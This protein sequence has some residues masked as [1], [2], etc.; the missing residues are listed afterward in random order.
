MSLPARAAFWL[1]LLCAV[2]LAQG[3]SRFRV[4]VNDDTGRPLR[5]ARVALAAGDRIVPCTTDTSGSCILQVAPGDYTLKAELSGFYLASEHVTVPGAP[6]AVTLYRLQ[7]IK[8]EVEV[9]ATPEPIE[10]QQTTERHALGFEQVLELPYTTS[11]QL[12]NA[13]LLLP[14][15]L[16]DNRGQFHVAG[17]QQYQTLQLMDGFD[18]SHPA[19]GMLEFRIN[20]DAVREIAT[21]TTRY[22]VEDGW[23]S[24]GVLALTT[25]M[26]DDRFR[27]IATNFIPSVQMVKGV[28]FDK[29]VP[30]LVVSG[31][32]VR[33]RAWFY[34]SLDGEY[35]E[36][37][38]KELPDGADTSI[39]W[40]VGDLTKVQ[41]NL[42]K[43]NILT[44]SLLLNRGQDRHPGISIFTPVESTP[45][46]D[47]WGYLA[48]VKDQHYFGRG[49]LLE[50]GVAVN[51]YTT[52][53]TPAG[54]APY[55]QHPGSVSGN[56]YL[57]SEAAARRVEGFAD[58]YAPPLEALGRHEFK[59][60][61][62]ANDL[63]YSLDAVR[64]PIFFVR[65]DGTLEHKAEFLGPEFQDV[66]TLE[67][68]AYVEDHW[69]VTPRFV[70]DPGVRVDW[71]RV[72]HQAVPQPRIAAS[73]VLP[74]E[75]TTKISAGAGAYSDQTN[76]DLLART[77][78][79]QDT[80]YA[81]DGV[82]PVGPPS[83]TVF[84]VD[85]S[86]LRVA[87]FLNWSVELEHE[88]P[89][90]LY[91]SLA[92]LDKHGRDAPLFVNLTPL[93]TTSGDYV[94]ESHRTDHYHAWQF[95]A[96]K[97][98][99]EAHSVFLAY[100]RSSATSN[101]V[102]DYSI[103]NPVFSAQ[104]G[105]PVAWDAPNRL[106]SWAWL[107]LRRK[108]DLGYFAEWHDGY[109]FS[110]FNGGQQ[111]VGSPN[112]RRFPDYFSLNV[113]VEYR[114]TLFH[115]VMAVRGGFDNITGHEN[116]YLVDN[117]T[118]SPTFLKFGGSRGRAFTT[119]IRFL[120]KSRK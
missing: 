34:Q 30:R 68:S 100:T 70:L 31:P 76:L 73:W 97:T 5:G 49:A 57:T 80:F 26:G 23:A 104:A 21:S 67:L 82:T 92:Y 50:A 32:I 40:H 60:G 14:Q 41:V 108:V 17:A 69:L 10:P 42:A 11:R 13:F 116:P 74:L 12:S 110:I 22:P 62:E 85:E 35:T 66:D 102:V 1:W 61:V 47:L 53:E 20:P 59:A 27:F 84:Q 115:H 77:G 91:V 89:W 72:A 38:V 2:A 39:L 4:T 111:L 51:S 36:N 8:E 105:G 86:R 88:L 3:P 120:G 103:E 28:N 45:I 52:N 78:E 55:I 37:I 63:A 119:R 25:G 114:F 87:R 101:A 46:V 6:L 83:L 15:V 94:L 48:S 106:I 19:T 7:E 75:R 43:N 95:T 117:N 99:T 98:F 64:R 118:S 54:D 113:H 33:G 16:A 81:A 24:G 96:S 65:S 112:E 29:F 93:A 44:T 18:V 107:P 71:D 79:R 109:P 58:V 9:T 56:F 90:K